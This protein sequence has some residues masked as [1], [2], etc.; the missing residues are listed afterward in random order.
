MDLIREL[1]PCDRAMSYRIRF[2]GP[3]VVG[4]SNLSVDSALQKHDKSAAKALQ[5]QC[6]RTKL[7]ILHDQ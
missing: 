7:Y 4:S 3:E 1:Q 2:S 6:R 5:K